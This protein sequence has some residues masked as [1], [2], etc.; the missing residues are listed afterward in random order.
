MVISPCAL[1]VRRARL[2]LDDVRLVELEL[3]GILDGDDALVLGDERRQH[4]EGRRLARTGAAGDEDVEPRLDTGAQELEHLRGRRPEVDEVVDGDRLGRE[5][6]HGDDR[7]DQR[8]RLDDRVDAR[9]VGQPRVDARAR[10]VDPPA[11]RGDDPVD[12][13]ED[14][15]VVQEVAVDPFDLAAALDVQ[16]ARPVD[17]DLGDRLVEQER[18]ERPEAADLAD[19]LLGQVL[20]LVVGDRETVDVEDA[21]DDGID[22]GRGAAPDPSISSN[23]VN[24]IMTSAWRRSRIWRSSASRAD[25][26]GRGRGH[27]RD[28]GRDD[29]LDGAVIQR[30]C[31]TLGLLDPLEQRHA[32]RPP[33]SCA[34]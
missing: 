31:A 18:V 22:L 26:R 13:A 3:G 10:R 11:E 25:K 12:D 1:E 33:R 24:A 7:T 23:V 17:H 4:V 6:P 14:V 34:A 28:R 15:L 30:A 5:L 19:Q 20:A 27:D 29:D 32:I 16:V 2:E 9:A 21:V 8:Q